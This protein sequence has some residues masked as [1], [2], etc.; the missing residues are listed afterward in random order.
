MRIKMMIQIS[1]TSNGVP[2][3]TPGTEIDFPDADA[4]TL[5]NSGAAVAVERCPVPEKAVAPKVEETREE[6]PKPAPRKPGRPRKTA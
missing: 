5:L 2:W 3:P 6:K 4:I 1:G